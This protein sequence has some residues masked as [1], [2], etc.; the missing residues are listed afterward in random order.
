MARKPSAA[1]DSDLLAEY[2]FSNGVRG[3]YLK[4]YRQGTNVVLLE[5]DVAQAF[6]DSA[7]VNS[8]LRVLVNVAATT[9]AK[10]KM[11]ARTT[12]RA[13]GGKVTRAR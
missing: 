1:A 6:P 11:T 5:P 3:K 12:R 13:R 2:D 9:V 10:P 7:A 8:A 4:A